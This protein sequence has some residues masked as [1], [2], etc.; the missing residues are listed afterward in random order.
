MVGPRTLS[1]A[2]QLGQL[3]DRLA[4]CRCLDLKPTHAFS[5]QFRQ[6]ISICCFRGSCLAQPKVFGQREI[7]HAPRPRSPYHFV[8]NVPTNLGHI[9][10]HSPSA[11]AGATTRRL[12]ALSPVP[13]VPAKSPFGRRNNMI[14]SDR[15]QRGGPRPF[16]SIVLP[17]MPP[18]YAGGAA[19]TRRARPPRGVRATV[20]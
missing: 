18:R 1:A 7:V 13:M 11:A 12:R 15:G 9:V 3:L 6:M 2:Q 14:G 20:T 16:H 5:S 19:K 8:S 4:A 17:P 10:T